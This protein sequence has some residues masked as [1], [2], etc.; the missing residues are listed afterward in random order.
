MAAHRRGF[1]SLVS[2]R[3]LQHLHMFVAARAETAALKTRGLSTTTDAGPKSAAP[4]AA[5]MNSRQLRI[6]HDM[7]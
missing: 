4:L 3:R 1:L 6:I 7:P 5:T 2:V